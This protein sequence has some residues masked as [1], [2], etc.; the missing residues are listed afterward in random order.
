MC[1]LVMEVYFF[2]IS[3]TWCCECLVYEDDMNSYENA[4]YA[5]DNK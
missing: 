5:F 1:S 2:S 3:E 4:T